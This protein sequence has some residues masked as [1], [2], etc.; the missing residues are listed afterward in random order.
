MGITLTVMVCGF[1]IGWSLR[2]LAEEI[3]K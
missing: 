2:G 3:L 1:M